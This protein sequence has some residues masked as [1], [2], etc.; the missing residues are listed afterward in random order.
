MS[1][2]VN[3]GSLLLIFLMIFLSM[4]I[5]VNIINKSF[6]KSFKIL[7]LIVGIYLIGATVTYVTIKFNEENSQIV[8]EISENEILVSIYPFLNINKEV[9]SIIESG[10]AENLGGAGAGL[11]SLGVNTSIAGSSEGTGSGGED[12]GDG[13]E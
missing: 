10:Y 13:G 4:N 3:I 6:K 1:F 2:I 11:T 12:C 9:T 7:I 5:V 8:R